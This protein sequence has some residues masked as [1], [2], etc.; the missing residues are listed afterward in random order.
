MVITVEDLKI[1][2]WVFGEK[3]NNLTKLIDNLLA[4]GLYLYYNIYDC[5]RVLY[6]RLY[7]DTIQA[8]QRF[9]SKLQYFT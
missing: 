5:I 4:T 3:F 9:N 1:N 2:D 8:K 6:N 7:T